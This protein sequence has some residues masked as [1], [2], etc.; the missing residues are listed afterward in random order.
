MYGC[1]VA[2]PMID[3]QI[4]DDNLEDDCVGLARLD[5]FGE[6]IISFLSLSIYLLRW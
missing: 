6:K 2:E 1:F 3:D 5:V 4:E